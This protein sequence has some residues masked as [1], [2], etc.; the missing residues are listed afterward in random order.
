[1]G[2]TFGGSRTS[3]AGRRRPVSFVALGR[4][5]NRIEQELWDAFGRFLS[6]SASTLG[7]ELARFGSEFDTGST[8]PRRCTGTPY[9]PRALQSPANRRWRRPGP[10]R[11]SRCRCT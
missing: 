4:Q 9:G 11:T 7:E 2:G 1:M 6:Q 5:H 10:P 8:M 3:G